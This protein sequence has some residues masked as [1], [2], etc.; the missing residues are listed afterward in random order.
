MSI[1]DGY[2]YVKRW[3]DFQHPDAKRRAGPGMAWIKNYTGLLDND[4]YLDLPPTARA[5]LHAIWILTARMGQGRCTASAQHLQRMTNFPAGHVQK[6]L[7]LL[8]HA[9]F[10][11]IRASKMRANRKQ[12]AS[13]EKEGSKEPQKEKKSARATDAAENGAAALTQEEKEQRISDMEIRAQEAGFH[14]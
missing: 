12:P 6:N 10:I 7:D 1:G 13:P 4:A 14:P 2:I 9:G 3:E 5:L 11:T 8:N